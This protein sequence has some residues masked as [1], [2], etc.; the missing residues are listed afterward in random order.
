MNP[1]LNAG[2]ATGCA[3]GRAAAVCAAAGAAASRPSHAHTVHPPATTA[4]VMTVAP[5]DF[6]VPVTPPTRSDARS[7]EVA[8]L[9]VQ[10]P[11]GRRLAEQVRLVEA[12][13]P[14]DADRPEGRNDAQADA[15]APEQARRVELPR[16]RPPVAGVDERAHVEHLGQPRPDLP[17]HRDVRLPARLRARLTVGRPRV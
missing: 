13:G 11:P 1:I 2:C 14:V 9:E 8:E 16:L 17:R 6:P 5:E 7:E 10:F 12:V 15:R 3:A 4:R